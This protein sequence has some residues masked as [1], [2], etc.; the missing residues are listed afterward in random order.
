[1]RLNINIDNY[2]EIMFRLLED[3]FDT[4]TRNDLLT[5][6][7]N[8]DLFKFEWE[9]W[10]KTRIIDPLENY[11]GESRE[12]SDKIILM[13]GRQP[14]VKKRIIYYLAAAS[15]LVLMACLTL[16]TVDFNPGNKREIAGSV[17]KPPVLEIKSPPVMEDSPVPAVNTDRKNPEKPKHSREVL[18]VDYDS[19]ALVLISN[20]L[21]EI[22]VAF[23][24]VRAETNEVALVQDKK[25]RYTV[26]TN[27]VCL[28]DYNRQNHDP[29]RKGKVKLSKVL[30]NTRLILQRKP[31]GEPGKIILMGE[32]NNSLCININYTEK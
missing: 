7:E 30:T 29:A 18:P 8:D 21:A 17:E 2:E 5:Q 32:D 28:V 15:I 20:T 31:N 1:M 26:T 3:D 11:S 22:P 13:A 25:T 19:N 4:P 27:T 23:D 6:I 12:L 14:V 10:Q 9:S 24:T 16:F